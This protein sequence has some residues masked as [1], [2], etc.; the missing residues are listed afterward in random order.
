MKK[1]LFLLA[2]AII[3]TTASAQTFT[4]KSNDMSGQISNKQYAN[5][6][7]YTGE[8]LSPQLSWENAPV[9]TQCFA[10][11]IYDKDA[12]SGSGFWHWV[13]YNI[14]ADTKEIPAGAGDIT[15]NLLPAGA[16]QGNTDMGK[17]GYVGAAPVP[18]LPHEYLVTVYALKSKL[19]IDKNATAAFI[20]FNISGIVIEKAS[21]VAYGQKR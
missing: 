21:I 14:P 15:K 1:I 9:G 13:V 18:G 16:I 11:T 3:C 12:P 2:T 7:G 17:P 19:T 8:N 4:L 20:G 10:I 5:F 6:M